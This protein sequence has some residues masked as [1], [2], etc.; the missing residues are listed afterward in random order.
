[1]Q[2]HGLITSTRIHTENVHSGAYHYLVDASCQIS[3]PPLLLQISTLT[4]PYL[5]SGGSAVSN[6]YAVMHSVFDPCFKVLDKPA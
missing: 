4:L 2:R 3:D 6:S 1:M 5:G